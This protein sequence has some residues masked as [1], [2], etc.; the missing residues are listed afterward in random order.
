MEVL[1]DQEMCSQLRNN[2]TIE[3]LNT[4]AEGRLI[5]AD[6]LA[7]AA[8]KPDVICDVATLTGAAVAALGLDIGALFSNDAEP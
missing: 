5:M 3:V 7:Y 8:E 1:S 6:A 4:D 2:K